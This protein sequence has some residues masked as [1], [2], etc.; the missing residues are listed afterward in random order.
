MSYATSPTIAPTTV[1]PSYAAAPSQSV[2]QPALTTGSYYLPSTNLQ[3]TASMV[4][5]PSAGYTF[6][7]APVT[8]AAP[9]TAGVEAEEKTET[10]EE[11]EKEKKVVKKK[12][13]KGCCKVLHGC[14]AAGQS[15]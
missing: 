3:Q 11:S 10:K 13:K 12:A 15:M 5:Y 8:V 2:I 9:V 7:A 14:H 4:A 1:V 6:S